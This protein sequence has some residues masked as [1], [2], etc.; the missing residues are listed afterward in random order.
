MKLPVWKKVL[1]VLSW[2]PTGLLFAAGMI[3]GALFFVPLMLAISQEK[4]NRDV[5]K[6]FPWGN[7]EEGCPDWWFK[8][9]K[10]WIKDVFPRWWWF[11]IRNPMNNSRYW[12]DDRKAQ[13]DTNW[14]QSVPMEAQQM[15]DAGVSDV[16]RWAYSGVFA[17]YRRVWLEDDGTYSERWFGWKVGSS[18]DGLGFATQNRRH[19]AIG[20]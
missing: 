11:S 14:D 17:G 8:R 2:I 4:N 18:V 7:E 3:A 12:F 15:I 19:I 20:N 6:W 16:Y 13:Y 10:H 9:E 1:Y 5:P